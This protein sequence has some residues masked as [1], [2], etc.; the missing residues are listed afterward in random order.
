MM[1]ERPPIG[2]ISPDDFRRV[3]EVFESALEQPP[4]E[5]AAFVERAL[6]GHSALATEVQ[7]MLA[8]ETTPFPLLDHGPQLAAGGLQAGEIF[9]N[10]FQIV[11]VLGRGGMGEVYRAHD[12]QLDRE[13]ALKLLPRTFAVDAER[14]A[15]FK[16]EAHVLGSL[17]HPNIAGIYGVEESEDGRALVL[18]LVEGPTLAERIAQGP[19]PI[20]DA[21]QAA[22]QI[23]E[24]LE[25][26]HEQGIVHRDLKPA[27][28]KLRPDGTV[29]VL[30]F[31]L[32]KVTHPEVFQTGDVAASPTITSRSMLQRGVVLGSAAY[33]SP[34]QA[35]G[36]EA[37]KRSDVWAF[38]AVLYEMLTA[39]RA[40]QGED[41]TDTLASVLRQDIDWAALP[42]S[43]PVPLRRLIERCLERDVTQRLRDIGEARIVLEDPRNLRVV[44]RRVPLRSGWSRAV[45]IAAVAIVAGA[46]GAA[47][48]WSMRASP[49]P[50]VA[51]LTLSLTDGTTLFG[52]RGVVAVSPDGTQV[53]YVTRSGLYLRSMSS[54]D[55]HLIRGSEDIF[56]IKEPAFSPDG[57][58][59]VFHTSA[60][61]TLRRI[62][63]SGGAAATIAHVFFPTGLRWGSG[64]ILFV[65]PENATVSDPNP[66]ANGIMRVSADGGVPEMLIA[67]KAGEVAYGPQLLPGEGQL[68]FT[69]ATRTTPDRWDKATVVVQSLSSG[70]RKVLI[71][72]GSD[73]RYL[74]SG[75]LV[76]AVA[77]S[78]F[79]VAFDVDSLEVRSA[80]VSVV[81]GVRRAD[82]NS[83]GGAHYSVSDNGTL[84]Y[85]AGPPVPRRDIA[86]TDRSGRSEW[87]RLPPLLYEAPRVS[88][89]GTRIIVGTDDG[90]EA[91]V[92]MYHL[93]GATALQRVTFGG[94]NRFPVWAADGRR[95]AFQSDREGDRGIFWQSVDG[96]GTAERLTTPGQDESHEPEAWSATREMLLFSI[97]KRTDVSLWTL[98]VKDRKAAPFGDVHSSTRIGGVFSPDGRWIA[99]AKSDGR[100][101]TIYVEPFPP[102]GVKHQLVVY[103]SELP[104]HPL[105]SP[106]GRE[107]FYNPGPGEFAS[108]A[109]SNHPTFVFGKPRALRRPFGG[110][111]TL[112]R[113]PYDIMPD[114]RFVSATE[115]SLA[116]GRP[117]AGE[118]HVV[119]NWF[120][121]LKARVP[122]TK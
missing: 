92:W 81:E 34:E 48:V 96:T 76:Y 68:L 54:F 46:V 119:L 16:R 25:A 63:A 45:S 42:A 60:D 117:A 67:L 79:A 93:S 28:I 8:A 1:H 101:K 5:R 69:L 78:L 88:P 11:D 65:Q 112:D 98:S 73:A 109:I 41:V 72:G 82:A 53:A 120:E 19:I 70:Q 77:G 75:H 84:V 20:E 36:R 64:G 86:L 97:T 13:V 32:A 17:N 37:D 18:E 85:V 56:N 40:F 26:A 35:R 9:A 100:R 51:R 12:G 38:G 52:S 3:R 24:A 104:N 29:K 39:R 111:S 74:P 44:A 66:R 106:D 15:R 14:L 57:Q 113:R 62:P 43:T 102:T 108:V 91:V 90:H 118:I 33:V 58:S 94:S 99:Y 83:T 49:V 87:L 114:G 6:N 50:A 110:A 71:E 2:T 59:I 31:G 95:V 47:A 115:G 89:D 61:Q 116:D 55:A 7:Q 21:G 30:D 23:A 122:P 105:W 27:N 22:R 121:E 107:L 10:R 80:P 4:N 103:G